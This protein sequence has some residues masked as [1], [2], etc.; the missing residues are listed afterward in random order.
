MNMKSLLVILVL[1]AVGL[2][3]FIFV[4]EPYL[5]CLSHQRFKRW[6]NRAGITEE[7]LELAEKATK[8][9]IQQ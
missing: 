9:D 7:M 2:P 3:L 6:M 4:V 1:V 5:F 8:D